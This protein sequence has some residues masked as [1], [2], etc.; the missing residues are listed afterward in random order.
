MRLEKWEM[1]IVE[2]GE[3]K[4]EGNE[5]ER[6][7]N[8]RKRNEEVFVGDIEMKVGYGGGGGLHFNSE[9]MRWWRRGGIEGGRRRRL[10][11]RWMFPF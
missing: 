1:D 7:T 2:R 8:K 5:K 6:K 9:K 11:D 3:E 10:K 4:V